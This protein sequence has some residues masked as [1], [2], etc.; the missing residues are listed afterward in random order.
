VLGLLTG[1]LHH[2]DN[3]DDNTSVIF[4]AFTVA[5]MTN[6]VFWAIKIQFVLHRRHITSPLQSSTGYARF[7]IFKAVVIKKLLITPHFLCSV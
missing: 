1:R 4:E 2:K 5:I 7:E 6:V 3:K